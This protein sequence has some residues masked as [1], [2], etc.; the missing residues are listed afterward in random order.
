MKN[1]YKILV[2]VKVMAYKRTRISSSN[3]KLI[4]KNLS[5]TSFTFILY[6]ENNKY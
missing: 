4:L 3:N 1:H 2:E 5:K 6:F